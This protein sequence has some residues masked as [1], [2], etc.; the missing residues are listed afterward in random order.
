MAASE[1]LIEPRPRCVSSDEALHTARLDA[2]AAYGDLSSF[3]ITMVLESDGWHI[4]YELKDTARDGGGPHYLIDSQS[5]KI[6]AK[7]YEQ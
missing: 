3:R 7:R 5:G 6:V 1:L 4:D 2:E